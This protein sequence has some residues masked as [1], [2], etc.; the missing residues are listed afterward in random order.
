MNQYA[1]YCQRCNNA[2]AVVHVTELKEGQKHEVHLCEECAEATDYAPKKSSKM[3]EFMLQ[4]LERASSSTGSDRECPD[5]GMTFAEFKAKG[6]FGC[7]K[8]YEIFLPR[9][10]PLLERIHDASS[11][12]DMPPPAI[13]ASG[14]QLVK[15][16]VQLQDAVSSEEY[17]RAANLRDQIRELEE[18]PVDGPSPDGPPGEELA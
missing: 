11:H 4:H 17:E 1:S 2:P 9:L 12:G 8:D 16:R 13:S 15:L 18:H 3:F 10:I 5:C 14:E 6:R 7:P